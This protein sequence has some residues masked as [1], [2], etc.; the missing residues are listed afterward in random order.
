MKQNL[1]QFA[2][3][4]SQEAKG[5][6]ICTLMILTIIAAAIAVTGCKAWRTV[7]TTASYVETCDSAKTTQTIT[8]RTVEEYQGKKNNR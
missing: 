7:T 3:K 5:L 8:T 1:K 4:Y 2:S 6:V